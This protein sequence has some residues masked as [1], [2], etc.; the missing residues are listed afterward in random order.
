VK[1]R[2]ERLWRTIHAKGDGSER[3]ETVT[4]A[5]AEP[6]RHYHNQKHIADCLIELDAARHLGEHPERIELALWF[7]DAVYEPKAADNEEQSAEMAKRCL[8]SAGRADLA[9]PIA[10]LIMATKLHNTD[11]NTDAALM[12]DVDLSILGQ[13]EKRFADYEAGI[14]AEYSWVPQNVFNGKRAEILQRFLARTRIYSTEHFF[15]KYERQA[16]KNLE[17]SVRKL[18]SESAT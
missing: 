17:Q 6:Q 5:Y 1:E 3:Y 18:T 15:A 13:S 2:W 16:R 10:A 11:A 8:E 14:R 4:L 9:G 12:V 7:H